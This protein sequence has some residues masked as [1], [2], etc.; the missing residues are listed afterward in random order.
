LPLIYADY[1]MIAFLALFRLIKGLW[2]EPPFRALILVEGLLL[3]GGM[4][5][6][7]LSEGWSW[8]NAAYFCVVTAATVGYGDLTP[9]TPYGRLF[10][11]FYVILSVA[12][13]G[14]FIQ[15]AGK[16]AYKGLQENVE[17]R[18]S[19]NEGDKQ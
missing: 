7:H 11:I 15:I 16:A 19:K 14:V 1:K 17:R 12:L 6:Y 13:L 5:F 4:V 2:R 3:A 10:T 9:T 18:Q 8:L